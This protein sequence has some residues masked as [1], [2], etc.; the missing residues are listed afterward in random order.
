MYSCMSVEDFARAIQFRILKPGHVEYPQWYSRFCR[1][2]KRDRAFLNLRLPYNDRSIKKTLRSFYFETPKMSTL[3]IG[4]IINYAVKL[5]PSTEVFVNVG[6]WH[7]YTLLCGM[8]GNPEKACVGVDNFSEFGG[9]RE[10]FLK[11]FERFKSTNHLFCEADY[12]EYF[13][14]IHTGSIGV[15]IY[16][17]EH[18]YANQLQGLRIAEPYLAKGCVIL[19]DDTDWIEPRTATVDFLSQ[20]QYKY[21]ILFDQRTE[22]N[23]HPTFW[24]G[25]MLLR[26]L[27]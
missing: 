19:V 4:A 8:V 22:V 11:R 17:A 5:M 7:G 25:I 27:D 6:I 18:S 26:K 16:D 9:P 24:N 23:A 20:S 14:K 12:I 1:M 10:E 15:Y 2:I 21:Q 3:A 13:A